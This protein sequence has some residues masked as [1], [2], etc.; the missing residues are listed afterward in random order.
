MHDS[1][2]THPCT[3]SPLAPAAL[4]SAPVTWPP[5]RLF[6]APAHLFPTLGAS[7]PLLSCLTLN[8]ALSPPC[9]CVLSHFQQ[10]GLNLLSPTHSHD[11]L[12]TKTTPSL[13]SLP[14]GHF[15]GT[16]REQ[17][18]SGE[19]EGPGALQPLVPDGHDCG[20]CGSAGLTLQSEMTR[21]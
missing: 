6:P 8:K 10:E 12:R 18:S 2:L 7:V 3:P 14:A 5:V 4:H 9:N 20:W 11:C 21:H 17:C 15:C 19:P 13:L 16:L 1:A